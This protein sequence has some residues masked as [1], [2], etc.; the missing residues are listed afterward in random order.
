LSGKGEGGGELKEKFEK[1]KTTI[2]IKRENKGG[3]GLV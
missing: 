3:G 1:K 2:Y